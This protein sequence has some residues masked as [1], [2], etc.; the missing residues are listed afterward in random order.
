MES[1][2]VPRKRPLPWA[3]AAVLA[4]VALVVPIL[5]TGLLLARLYRATGTLVPGIIA[6]AA[7]NA[8]AFAILFFAL[9]SAG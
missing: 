1:A 9:P 6:H 5:L 8:T 3:V 7:N 4:A 2:A